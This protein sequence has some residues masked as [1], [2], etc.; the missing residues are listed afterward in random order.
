MSTLSPVHPRLRPPSPLAQFALVIVLG[1][2]FF[3]IALVALST[4]Y[5]L[6]HLRQIYPGVRVANVDVGGL[7]PRQAA[8]RVS[9]Q[10]TYPQT[11]R[12]LFVDGQQRWL[13]TP[14]ELGLFLDP[15]TSAMNAYAAGRSGGPLQRLAFLAGVDPASRTLAPALIFDERLAYR[16]L[17]TLARQINRPTVEASIGLQG[18]QVVT[19]PGQVGRSL[20]IP[21]SLATLTPLIYSQQDGIVNLLVKETPPVILDAGAQ[22]QLAQAAL[23][24]PLTLTMPAE[25]KDNSGPWSIDPVNLAGML[26]FER[27]PAGYRLALQS[28]PVMNY[29]TQ[30]GEGLQR[31]P[32]NARFTFN[33]ETRKLDLI[34][35]AVVGRAL[36]VQATFQA[37]QTGLLQNQHSIPLVFVLAEPKVTDQASTDQ[38]GVRELVHAETSYFYGSSAA[39]IQNITAAASQFH[40]LLIAPGETFSMAQYLGDISLDNGYA[41]A[42]IIFGNKTIKGIGGGVCQVSTTL[43]RTAFF[44]GYPINERHAHAY[45]VYYYEKSAGNRINASL[46]GLDATVFVP[47]VDFKFTNDTPYW[48]LMET[49]VNPRASSITWKFYS[50]RDGRT[51]D[52]NTSGPVNIVPAPEIE[53][54]ENSDLANGEI[55]QVEWAADGA[56]VTVTRTV[57]RNGA[58]IL[59]DTFKTHYEPWGDV[60]EYG[61][62]T[63]IPPPAPPPEG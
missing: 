46:A 62:G 10:Y 25:Q 35:P 63:E 53:Y 14:L 8:D 59:Q 30:L 33:D 41:E 18:T 61:P 1:A 6:T 13:A 57:T 40:G 22:A 55:K 38:L 32:R 48:L 24:Q 12:I 28:E 37:I 42:S 52:W 43:F 47:L 20:D 29:L 17:D 56:D 54:R 27:T 16:Y 9:Q 4:G 44:A 31:Y 19:T 15:E 21:A 5:Q 23:S 2:V 58:V 60:Y 50:T 34:Q 45:R 49:Y 39:R 11:G 3:L 51:V 7:A 26:T 36:D